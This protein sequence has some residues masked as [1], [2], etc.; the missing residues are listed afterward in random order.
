[1]AESLESLL[2][3]INKDWGGDVI[4]RG[5]SEYDY[6][7]IPFTS[8]RLNYI[9]F[10]GIPQ[11]KLIEFYGEEHGGKTT[12]ALDIVAN[13][14]HMDD[15]KSVLYV[16]A[17]NTLDTVWANKLGVEVEDMLIMNPTTQG[18]ETIFEQILKLIDT[19]EIGLV[20]IDS[21]GVMMSNQA[22]EKSVEEK[23]YGG[24]AM[25]LTNFSKKAEALCHKHNCTL[26]GINQMRADMNSMYGGLTTTGGKAW[27]H[28]VSARFEF[29]RG[30]FFDNKYGKLT[31]GAENPVG[32]KVEVAMTKNKT[33]PPTRRTGFYTL[34]YD[35]GIDY[36][37]DLTEVCKKYGVIEQSG[38]WFEL[39][40]PETQETIKKLQGQY[41]V[42]E[43]LSD[44][45]NAD[46]LKMYEDYLET[47]IKEN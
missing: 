16:D 39:K 35:I 45:D 29:R 47:K 15:A 6:K 21:L 19:G 33:C 13:Y 14:Q 25:A 11:G 36:M 44:E 18:A 5:V 26:I 12:T 32:N 37:Y 17:E 10:G 20:I 42:F 41:Q 28:N 40:N 3:S 24:I 27:K 1:M 7:R 9:S 46:V 38:A 22:Y 30:E 23:T 43:F 31:R 2:K 4:R 8:P 34:R